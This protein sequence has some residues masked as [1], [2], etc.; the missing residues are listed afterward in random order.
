MGRVLEKIVL[1]AIVTLLS[2]VAH[3]QQPTFEI[4][5]SVV[6]INSRPLADATLTLRSKEPGPERSAITGS[7]GTFSFRNLPPGHYSL[8]ASASEFNPVLAQHLK[9]G[10]E[11]SVLTLRLR[12]ELGFCPATPGLPHYFRLL[13]ARGN[14]GPTAFSGSVTDENS[15]AIQGADVTLYIPKLG[16]IASTHTDSE[17]SFTFAH[18]AVSNDYWVQISRAGYFVA[19]FTNLESLSGYESVYDDLVLEAG[20]PGHCD[21]NLRKIQ[22]LRCE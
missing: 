22:A 9:V 4:Q 17:G 11:H 5:G 3:G 7:N 6:D 13:D 8:R 12:M 20:E 19:E 1:A 21:Q 14:H 15:I 16:R 10:P 2:P 18:L